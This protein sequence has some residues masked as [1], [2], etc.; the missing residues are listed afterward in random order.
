MFARSALP[1]AALSLFVSSCGGGSIA[2]AGADGNAD[3][4]PECHANADCDDGLACNGIERCAS[5]PGGSGACVPGVRMHCDD[6]VACTVDLCSDTLGRCVSRVPDLDMDGHGAATCLDAHGTPLGDDCDDHDPNDFPGNTEVC[7]AQMHDEDCNPATHGGIDA[8][9]D[10]FEDVRCCNGALGSPGRQCGTDCDDAHASA[11]PGATEVC[12]LIDDD[13]DLSIDEMVALSGFVDG[14]R[15]GFGDP[16]M[17]RS[18]CGSAAHFAVDGTDCDD[19]NPARSPGQVEFCDGV[20]NDCDTIVDETPVAVSWYV[21]HDGDGYGAASSGTTMSCTPPTGYVLRGTDCDDAR[22]AV[23]PAAPEVCN[24]ID[25]DCNGLADFVIAPGDLEDDDHDRFPDAHCGAPLGDDCD[26]RDPR[27][28][29]GAA[30]ICDGRDN[31]C[32]GAVDEGVN[33]TVFYRDVDGDGYGDTHIVRV[34]CGGGSGFVSSGGDCDDAMSSR[35]PGAVEACNGVDDDC[36]GAV[37]EGGASATCSAGPNEIAACVRGA[38]QTVGCDAGFAHCSGDPQGCVT[39]IASDPLHCGSCG[40]ACPFGLSS[41]VAGSCGP[42]LGLLTSTDTDIGDVFVERVVGVPGTTN[43]IVAGRFSGTL[44]FGTPRTTLNSVGGYDGFAFEL[45]AS[46]AVVWATSWGGAGND[47]IHAVAMTPDGGAFVVGGEMCNAP[48]CGGPI[49]SCI[50][51]WQRFQS[52]TM[53]G[54]DYASGINGATASINALAIERSGTTYLVYGAGTWSGVASQ[55]LGPANGGLDGFVFRAHEV[56]SMNAQFDWVVSFDG[57]RDE[58]PLDIAIDGTGNLVVVGY[59]SSIATNYGAFPRTSAGGEDGFI[60]DVDRS[61]GAMTDVRQFGTAA[62]D[63]ADRV[64]AL[65][66]GEVAV[67]GTFAAGTIA[68]GSLMR[69]ATGPQNAF[70]AQMAALPY[71]TRWASVYEGSVRIGGLGYVDTRVLLAADFAG[72]LVTDRTP[73]SSA[74]QSTFLAAFDGMTGATSFVRASAGG[75]SD[76]SGGVATR[77]DGTLLWEIE[78]AGNVSLLGTTLTTGTDQDIA[79]VVV[80]P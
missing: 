17:P 53:G 74:A 51:F 20:D 71:A 18:A 32:D 80:T 72:S 62:N 35:H 78:H 63:R 2:D 68:I 37:D 44:S 56:P 59:T 49:P 6:V 36:D 12:N 25:D 24:A 70:V 40:G 29:P 11:H 14:D 13:C 42:T 16:A 64:L 45:G 38:C 27:S 31:D 15:D 33:Q 22:A 47:A 52:A 76:R 46:G 30:E 60:A 58:V 5:P 65:P 21:D 3:A 66:N 1:L 73:V 57:A 79:T 61:T 28:G 50:G 10:T 7:D 77:S 69:T 67:A 39:D 34:G 55:S 26:D 4:A 43:Y 75:S 54:C 41:C 48:L 23:S 9:A 19:T 8:D